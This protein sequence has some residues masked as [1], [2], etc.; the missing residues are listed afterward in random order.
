MVRGWGIGISSFGFFSNGV[1]ERER[2][3]NLKLCLLQQWRRERARG[4]G[5]SSF[6]SFSN[7]V[8]REKGSE[9]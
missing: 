4:I 5:I 1:A 8:S 2:A 3:C 6:G 9:N 7:G